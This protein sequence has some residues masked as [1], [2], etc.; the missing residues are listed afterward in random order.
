MEKRLSLKFDLKN[1]WWLFAGFILTL[2]PF[3][4]ASYLFNLEFVESPIFMV[5][6][7]VALAVIM[8][9]S[10]FSD[11]E[12]KVIDINKNIALGL[13]SICIA[14]SF[15]WC[16]SAYFNDPSKYSFE[17]Q[18]VLISIFSIFCCISFILMSI[19]FFLGKNIFSNLS[20]FLFCPA[21]WF[22]FLMI[23]F[24]S[25]QNNNADPYDVALVSAM[26]LFLIY[27]TQVFST[28]SGA[29]ISKLMF[30]FGIP[31]II[32]AFTKCT[33]IILRYI[34]HRQVLPVSIATNALEFFM[35]I[36][37]FLNLIEICKQNEKSD[38]PVIKSMSID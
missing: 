4:V 22:G 14:V 29:N 23:L 6:Y 25:I 20:F 30:V 38:E 8:F 13:I 21:I 26:S 16:I 34:K 19:T 2:V 35:A 27:Y 3:K 28:A 32:L 15:F 9:F 5:I 12:I 7:G 24:L 31:S 37:I 18:P 33:P 11:I 36:F 17:I 10:V 1:I